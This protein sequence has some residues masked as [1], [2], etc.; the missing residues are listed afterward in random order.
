MSRL[1]PLLQ[2]AT[3][4][5][6]EAGAGLLEAFGTP[7]GPPGRISKSAAD[8][9]A[10]E[11]L[12]ERLLSGPGAGIGWLAE[13]D[14][15]ASRPPDAEGRVWVVDPNDGTA[16]FLRGFRG[17]SVS[18]GLLRQGIP[19]LGVVFA[20]AAPDDRGDLIAWAEG[21][22]PPTRNGIPIERPRLATRLTGAHTVV[23]S[24]HGDVI[25]AASR[26]N[27]ELTAPARFRPTPGLAYR[28]ALMA[29]G[30]AEAAVSL[31]GPSSWDMAGGHALIRA[32]GGT[33]VNEDGEPIAYA[34]DGTLAKPCR[35]CIAG[36][37]DAAQELA[38][39]DWGALS[40]LKPAKP[41]GPEL[42]W[43]W[44]RYPR[45][46]VPT[47]MLHRAQG[48]LLGQLA[49]DA[50]GSLVE[51]QDAASVRSEYP[52]GPWELVDG[53][54]WN[55]LA[56]QPTDDSELALM[57]ARALVKAGKW[58]ARTVAEHYG[59]WHA[60][61]PFDIGHTTRTALEPAAAHRDDAP[62]LAARAAAQA[63]R[64][65]QANGALMR[66]SPLAV[67]GALMED[68]QQLRR[69]AAL[70]AALTHPHPVCQDANRVFSSTISYAIRHHAAPRTAYEKA[71][72]LA[73]QPHISSEIVAWLRQA[74]EGLPVVN[75]SRKM[76]WVR[77]AFGNAF[78]R[79]LHSESLEDAVVETVRCGGDTDTNAAIC[80]ALL[81]AVHGRD[82]IP[83]QWVDRVLTC[84]PI[85]GVAGVHRPRPRGMWPVD[86]LVLAERLLQA[87]DGLN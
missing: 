22:G 56:G 9:V 17:P 15:A 48:A 74:D 54:T 58:D 10:E 65:S 35:W 40:R 73:E 82:A 39:R 31:A 4:A 76:G 41:Q 14:A 81:G 21:C 52:N 77:I 23:L 64:E 57:L 6:T 1:G 27:A 84:R 85:K 28:L 37:P 26:A 46:P 69:W 83:K 36:H 66:I 16:S 2:L 62:E 19:V 34:L 8:V 87:G 51:F 12:R 5:A 7:G 75:F 24:Q 20:Y 43:P 33:L 3:D 44:A 42:V 60:S 38:S 49:G 67:M 79:L 63:S 61:G 29:A 53:G 86:A 80:G 25:E 59:Y 47:R 30:E 13:E 78:Y 11:V 50:L 45:A 55:T 18:I 72:E 32:F 71:M 68:Q 70:D